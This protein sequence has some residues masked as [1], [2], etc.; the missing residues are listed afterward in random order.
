MIESLE[1]LTTQELKDILK[2]HGKATSGNN[3]AM[4]KRIMNNKNHFFFGYFGNKRGEFEYIYEEF[5]KLE[6][7]DTIYEP[8]CGSSSFS[9]ILSTRHPKKYK[10]ILNDNNKYL[11]EL[12]NIVK[13][14]KLEPFIKECNELKRSI[15]IGG[16]EKYNE[17]GKQDTV[18]A[19]LIMNK[20]H[21]IR[22]G[23]FPD[24]Y[25]TRFENINFSYLL[26]CPMTKFLL[27][28][29]VTITNNMVDKID[30]VYNKEN[31]FTFLDPPYISLDNDYYTDSNINIYEYL[32][33]NDMNNFKCK[34]LMILNDNWI[35]KFIFKKYI[36][37]EYKKLYQ[38]SKKTINHVVI[39]NF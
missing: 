8:F 10:Y 12:Y 6:G 3:T 24:D 26:D 37:N 31:I 25:K 2:S 39:K 29:D 21:K 14:D 30:D 15:D 17:I 18:H 1:K 36:T 32:A 27:T 11:C 33:Y 5:K 35:I 28:E 13:G 19:Y 7:I 34:M 16:K 38:T 9:Y 4:I 23:I 22:Q 20:I